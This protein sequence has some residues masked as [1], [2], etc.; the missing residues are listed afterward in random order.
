MSPLSYA[1]LSQYEKLDEEHKGLFKGIFDVAAAP[2]DAGAL[3]GLVGKVK[4]HFETEEV[5]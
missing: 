3:S 5:R 1:C 2:G 4:S